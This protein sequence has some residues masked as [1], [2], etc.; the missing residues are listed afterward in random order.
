M[1]LASVRARQEGQSGKTDASCAAWVLSDERFVD[2][3]EAYRWLSAKR[4]KPIDAEF[5]EVIGSLEAI[6]WHSSATDLW[7]RLEELYEEWKLAKAE[8]GSAPLPGELSAAEGCLQRPFQPRSFRDFYAFEQHV[9]TCRRKRGLDMVPEWYEFPVFYFS[10][11][12]S[13]LGP[14]DPVAAPRG[15]R[16]L[17]FE[18]EVACVI[19]KPGKSIPVERA[20]EYIAGFLVLNDWSARD[21]Q[22]A[23]MKV[24]L[25][26]AKGKD[27]ATSFGPYLVTPDE[28]ADVAECSENGCRH[29]I[30]MTAA[31]NGRV[32]S[33]GNLADIHYTFAQMIERASA[34][35]Q[36]LPGD[37]LGSGTVGT[38][39]I[40]ELGTEIQ[41]W[42]KPGD[43]VELSVERL[44]V[45]R[46]PIVA[47]DEG[48]G[49]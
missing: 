23:E 8:E 17:D 26:P 39:C 44:G 2:I 1:K 19:K 48:G 14:D 29:R 38:G 40:L 45:L 20:D 32:I 6:V 7:D 21:I 27:F 47:A 35:V 37:V 9:A 43:T 36:L 10:N 16:E 4:G 46:T 11:A 30:E 49:A 33:R 3:R 34:D 18:L 15:C 28:L 24:G 31:V 22:R 42:L 5:L 25:G 13:F 41:D 12:A